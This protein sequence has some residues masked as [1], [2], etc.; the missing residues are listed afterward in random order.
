MVNWGNAPWD[1][2]GIEETV[3]LCCARTRIDP[4]TSERITYLVHAGIDWDRLLRL[5]HRNSVLPLVYR[6]LNTT[7]PELVPLDT[8]GRLQTSFHASSRR[9]LA[10]SLELH[11]L[12]DRF[13]ENGICAVPFKGPVLAAG[14]YGNLALRQFDDLDILLDDRDVPG[15]LTVMAALGYEPEYAIANDAFRRSR[16]GLSFMRDDCRVTVDLHWGIELHWSFSPHLSSHREYRRLWDRLQPLSVADRE[17]MTLSPEDSLLLL[18]VHGAKHKWA[19]LRWICD[20]AEIVQSH[21]ALNWDALIE[22]STALHGRRMLFLALLL[23]RGALGAPVPEHVMRGIRADA[24][25]HVPAVQVARDVFA[26]KRAQSEVL[27]IIDPFHLQVMDTMVDK[28][29]YCVRIAFTPTVDDWLLLRLP[30]RLFSLY[31]LVRPFRL[32]AKHGRRM[33]QRRRKIARPA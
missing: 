28:F 31:Y 16:Q 7:C 22:T 27:V 3:L 6:S 11:R 17:V 26:D 14:V 19:S 23:A 24:M 25:V 18:S 20:I 15:Q 21:N 33:W 30:S 9:N 4:G 12:L 29:R 5:A 8:L 1:D 10:L 32:G 13:T 2:S